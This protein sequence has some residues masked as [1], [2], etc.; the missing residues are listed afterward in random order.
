[1]AVCSVARALSICV[2]LALGA[3]EVVHPSKLAGRV[4]VVAALRLALGLADASGVGVVAW[5]PGVDAGAVDVDP[6]QPLSATSAQ[7]PARAT[8]RARRARDMWFSMPLGTRTRTAPA[9]KCH[10][11]VNR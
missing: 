6:P 8:V 11:H 9:M 7:A 10:R 2:A 4:A 1:M 3:G 5:D